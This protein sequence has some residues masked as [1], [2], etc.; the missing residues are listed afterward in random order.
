MNSNYR[1]G[2]A[3][4]AL[5]NKPSAIVH[6]IGKKNRESKTEK[7]KPYLFSAN[8]TVE[9]L[10]ADYKN[11]TNCTDSRYLEANSE[12]DYKLVKLIYIPGSN[13]SISSIESGKI[14]DTNINNNT[15]SN[16]NASD[17]SN[18]AINSENN[19]INVNNISIYQNIN[20]SIYQS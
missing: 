14:N 6:F 11:Y 1:D 4:N 7:Y 19:D 12:V 3:I 9:C 18:S 16:S 17:I 15:N 20:I 10:N 5:L 2:D 13:D 8:T